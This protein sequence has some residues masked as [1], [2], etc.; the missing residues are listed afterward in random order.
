MADE[1]PASAEP[2]NPP[3]EEQPEPAPE[4]RSQAEEPQPTPQ[5][6]PESRRA[7]AGEPTPAAAPGA[8]PPGPAD[9]GMGTRLGSFATG[10]PATESATPDSSWLND[11]GDADRAPDS[12]YQARINGGVTTVGD[13][14]RT[15]IYN[16][17]NG[18]EI[19]ILRF[20]RSED[21]LLRAEKVFVPPTNFK[22]C[23]ERL[24]KNRVLYLRGAPGTGRRLYAEMLLRTIVGPKRVLGLQVNQQDVSLSDLAGEHGLLNDTRDHGVVLELA[25]P[26]TVG[27][28][29]LATLESMA[30]EGAA[31]T[32]IVVLGEWSAT[33]DQALYPYDALAE[34]VSPEDVFRKHLL[35]ERAERNAR[36]R[37]GADPDPA[38]FVDRCLRHDRVRDR[39]KADPHPG[40]VADLARALAAWDG[41]DETLG[42]LLNKIRARTRELAA[43]L[44]KGNDTEST[45]NSPSTPRR[46]AA[47]IAYATFDG[48]PLG[49]VFD[50]GQILLDILQFVRDGKT[51]AA[52]AIFDADIEQMLRPAKDAVVIDQ[53]AGDHPRRARFLDPTFAAEVLGVVWN[54]FDNLRTPLLFWLDG[55]VRSNQPRLA[56]RA[57]YTAGRFATEDFEQVWG[58]SIRRWAL[59]GNGNVRQAATWAVDALATD[60]RLLGTVRSRVRD[61]AQ[62]NNP[63]FHDT[64]ARSYG[65]ALGTLF[66]DEALAGLRMLA[67]RDDLNGSASVAYS[68]RFLYA[69]APD[70]VRAALG[71]WTG[72]KLYRL[73][74]HA[75]RT[76]ILLA[77]LA[78]PAP[79]EQWPRLLADVDTAEDPEVLDDLWRAALTDPTTMRRAWP[80]LH[81]WLRWGDDDPEL[82]DRVVSLGCRILTG[83]TEDR[84][85]RALEQRG[86]FYL[87]QWRSTCASAA[88]LYTEC[89]PNPAGAHR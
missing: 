79:R 74:V 65:T 35:Q 84:G 60:G 36:G 8:A 71:S 29:T 27:P 49:D 46:Q 12:T 38:R 13:N 56:R 53:D 70:K 75:A 72:D 89:W 52:R 28:A 11:G 32:F 10:K 54:D 2:E 73:R 78:A 48:H 15:Y 58:L 76:L 21:W 61:W 45:V 57:A 55:L 64:A 68:M 30:S 33:L 24:A 25:A 59:D 4:P 62:S 51:S 9:D 80:E 39:L 31:G 63:Q 66:P 41:T 85:R 6:Q 67:R 40:A 3:P 20:H 88:R 18:R 1:S 23:Y 26:G 7:T 34:P 16:L 43:I 17:R 14:A 44:V 47:Q 83:N 42:Q 69:D 37:P 5:P 81:N 22:D 86:R 82:E 50:T 19:T 77:R 87:R